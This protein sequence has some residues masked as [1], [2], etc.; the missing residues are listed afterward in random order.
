M[1][2]FFS[3]GISISDT[4]PTTQAHDDSAVVG[5]DGSAADALHKHGMP[6]G[7]TTIQLV[8]ASIEVLSLDFVLFVSMFKDTTGKPD[9]CVVVTVLSSSS[10]ALVEYKRLGDAWV[11]DP[12][13]CANDASITLNFTAANQSHITAFAIDSPVAS[14]D[15]VVYIA[16]NNND[17]TD[18]F[19]VDSIVL[20]PGSSTL[21]AVPVVIAGS[22]Q[23]TDT[24]VMSTCGIPLSTTKVMTFFQDDA[25][26]ADVTYSD[27]TYTFTYNDSKVLAVDTTISV[28]GA[29]GRG[30]SGIVIGDQVLLLRNASGAIQSYIAWEMSVAAVLTEEFSPFRTG[31]MGTD[32]SLLNITP[33]VVTAI[34]GVFAIASTVGGDGA[35]GQR[36]G[37]IIATFPL[38]D[39]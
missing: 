35:T 37:Y 26:F 29:D 15:R 20:T 1:T 39:I 36:A 8:P 30:Y 16:G 31:L 32:Q 6:A 22:N 34:D 12:V 24:N 33:C 23:P 17:A 7:G 19:E 18:T 4:T 11:F 27:P 3:S 25:H 10:V 14:N 5:A 38:D 21:T 28:A 13:D 9:R 2:S